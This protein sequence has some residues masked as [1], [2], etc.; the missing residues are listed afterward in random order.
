MSQE[1]LHGKWTVSSSDEEDPAPL[2]L[3]PVKKE[4]HPDKDRAISHGKQTTLFN[5]KQEPEHSPKSDKNKSYME[6]GHHKP[7]VSGKTSNKFLGSGSEER[8]NAPSNEQK[9]LP[10]M[11]SSD[12]GTTTPAVKR[13]K[14]IENSGWCLSSSDE[15]TDSEHTGERATGRRSPSPKKRK[16]EAE[17]R[18]PSPGD[19]QQ[20][21]ES[22]NSWDLL[23]RGEPFRFYLNK[24]TGISNRS[25]PLLIVHGE[26]RESKVRLHEE[27]HPYENVRLCQAKLDIAFGTHHTK[28]MLLLYEEGFRVVI[29]TSNLIH[30]DWY[31]KTQGIWLSPLY[32]KLPEGSSDTAGESCTNFK[33]DLIEYLVSYRSPTL[34][35]WIN[36]IKEYDLSETRVYLIGSSP[37]RYQGAQ[38]EKWGHLKLRKLLSEHASSDSGE[39]TWPVIGQY[40]SI[41]SLGA[42]KTKWLTSE[43]QQTL[44]TL[45]KGVTFLPKHEIP[46]HLLLVRMEVCDKL[47][48][49]RL[50]EFGFMFLK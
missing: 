6:S 29:H 35:E 16:S 24:V 43:F 30:D 40:S 20:L 17:K 41:G 37:G 25:K 13:K 36:H 8:K 38:K 2:S 26:K 42:D 50:L 31:Q 12:S 10:F 11:T 15:E 23:E 1:S 28:M 33:H 27:A 49:H 3:Q 39:E 4:E 32:P 9:R 47:Q 22:L 18:S 14:E 19:S 46:L 7:S 45:Q 44:T 21:N 5:V 48:R 34:N